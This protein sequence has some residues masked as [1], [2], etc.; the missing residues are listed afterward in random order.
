MTETLTISY[1][2]CG[3]CTAKNHC[4]S[5]G[6]ELVQSLLQRPGIEAAEMNIP[7]HTLQVTHTLDA[8]DLEDLLDGMGVLVG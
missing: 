8:D 4:K 6:A 7:D 5:C 2:N 1:L 3:F